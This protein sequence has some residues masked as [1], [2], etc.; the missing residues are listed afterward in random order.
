MKSEKATTG[1]IILSLIIPGW[2]FLI[3]I[4][5]LIKREFKRGFTMILLSGFMIAVII[6]LKFTDILNQPVTTAN[7]STSIEAELVAAANEVNRNTP[8]MIDPETRLDGAVAG[9]GLTFT[10]R[11][12]LV[13]IEFSQI[14]PGVFEEKLAPFVEKSGCK[15]DQLKEFFNNNI[16]VKYEYRDSKGIPVGTVELNKIRCIG[17]N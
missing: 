8:S 7:S 4:I 15:S 6:V 5:A 13:T 11:Y 16:T 17:I 1:D 10:Y 3:G 9:P 12:T 2:G 14:A